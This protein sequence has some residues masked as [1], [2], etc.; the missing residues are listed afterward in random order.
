MFYNNRRILFLPAVISFI[1]ALLLVLKFSF[2][3]SWDVYYHIHMA[4]LYMSNGLVFWD[5]LTVAPA[6]RLIMY[7]PL[8]HLFLAGISCITGLSLKDVCVLLE[9]FFTFI[10]VGIITYMAYRLFDNV[11]YGFFTGLFSMICFATFNRG[12]ICT[13]ATIT[14]AFMII[15]CVM[16]YMGFN[17]NK[18]KY[19]L[20]SAVS[21]G[22]IANLHMATFIITCGVIGLYAVVQLIRGKINI[23]YLLVFIIVSCIIALPW[24]IYVEIK[25]GLFFNSLGGNPLRFDEFLA[26]YFGII[27][28]IFMIIGVYFLLKKRSEK[29]L[30]L[31]L[32]A[33]SIV[34]V[35]QVVYFGVQTVSIRIL[36]ISAYPLVFIAGYGF[37][38]V[39]GKI[40]NK[41]Y[42]KIVIILLLI[43]ATSTSMAYT[44]SY[45]P[46]L[47]T[48]DENDIMI[49]PDSI[50]MVLDPVGS[51]YKPS[52]ISSRYENS[53][54]AHDRYDVMEW[55]TNNTDHKIAVCEDSI[56]DTIIV[57]TSRT[58]VIYGGFTESIPEYVV[59]PVHIIE[60]HS[61]VN[62]L[63]DLNIEYLV[64]N[65]DTPIPFYAKCVY[66]NSNYK[67]CKINI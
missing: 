2:P 43:Y 29:S 13:P 38:Q 40:T 8:F 16:F 48:P 33:F 19:V 59:D 26:K 12:V 18:L 62:E 50:H 1:I 56:L 20:I 10:L 15:C 35:S 53:T 63:H 32:W 5:Y 3:I 11:K 36:E 65:H 44:D 60:N 55:F 7:P 51:T 17:D 64:L 67:I 14:M 9:P 37:M 54:L 24:W 23:K 34:C 27:P 6:G 42:K 25:Y 39:I 30:F 22:L 66:E 41:N 61:T 45:T 49:L 21:L 47:L 28:T 57:S 46:E 52:I 58:P 31:L 4:D